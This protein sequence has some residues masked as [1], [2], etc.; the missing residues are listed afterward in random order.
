MM[1]CA[2]RLGPSLA[3]TLVLTPISN[4]QASVGVPLLE[5]EDQYA[6]ARGKARRMR[7]LLV[8]LAAVLKVKLML[9]LM[10]VM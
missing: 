5:V 4:N 10:A 3:G 6:V 2:P 1:P 9:G 8:A 7:L